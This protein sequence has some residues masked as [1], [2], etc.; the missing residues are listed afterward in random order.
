MFEYV[1]LKNFKSFGDVEFNLLDKAGNPKNLILVYGENGIGKSNLASAFFLLS[2][3]LRTM[4]VRDMLER[5]LAENPEHIEDMDFARFLKMRF[6]DIEALVKENKTVKS[7]GNMYVEF[8]FRLKGK[9]G[10]YII[11]TNNTEIV[12]EHLEFTLLRNRGVYFDITPEKKSINEKIFKDKALVNEIRN[13]CNK[14]WGKHTFLSIIEHETDDKAEN[15]FH[16]QITSQFKNVLGFFSDLSCKVKY[17][18]RQERGI[19]GLPPEIFSDYD[20]GN[21]SANQVERLNKAEQ[22]LNAFFTTV[23]RDITKAYYKQQ[24]EKKYIRY[25]LMLRKIIAGKERDIDF[26]LESTGT[27]SLLQ[28]LPFLLVVVNGATVVIDEFDIGIHD[29]LVR[30]LVTSLNKYIT[31]QIIMTTHNTLLMESEVPKESIYV[32]NETNGGRKEIKCITHYDQKIHKNTNMRDQYLI[33][34]YNGIPDNTSIDFSSL[35]QMIK[36]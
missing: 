32:I 12:H 36:K 23:Y 7:S 9:S 14:F 30:S 25:Q 29:I 35:L 17:G 16:N 21:I 31:G 4:N 34:K 13:A 28:L 24:K 15:Y 8:G 11:E 33:G 6:R 22:M 26:S 1:K 5:I 3:S 20:E 27:Q 2:E 18:S 10:K 19:I